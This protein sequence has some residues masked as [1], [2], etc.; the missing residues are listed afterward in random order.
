MR[1]NRSKENTLSAFASGQWSS[2]ICIKKPTEA[3]YWPFNGSLFWSNDTINLALCHE[4]PLGNVQF[5]FDTSS[6]VAGLFSQWKRFSDLCSVVFVFSLQFLIR[7]NSNFPS[8]L[9]TPS[10]FLRLHNWFTH[11]NGY[12]SSYGDGYQ[13]NKYL[14]VTD[15][16]STNYAIKISLTFQFVFKWSN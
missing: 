11:R 8:K 14:I 5:V 15:K 1:H 9:F 10:L 2:K 13:I 6:M 7:L 3:N 4:M 12:G 16:S